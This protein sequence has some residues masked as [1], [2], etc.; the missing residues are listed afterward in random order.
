[1]TTISVIVGSI[2]QG[3]FS[4]LPAKWIFEHLK[5]REGVDARLLDLK[6]FPL[7][8]FDAPMAPAWPGRPPYEHPEVQRWTAAIAGSDAYVFVTPEYNFGASGV[9][10]NA[11]DWVYPEW[12]RKACAFVSFGG[13]GGARA[14][15]Q[16]RENVIELQ[17]APIRTSVHIP[18]ATL[19][20]YFQGA[21][22][23]KN[24]A[25]SDSN[26][27]AMIDELLWW[28]EALQTARAKSKRS[29]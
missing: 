3:R 10:K 11:I 20:A 1:M 13:A 15:Q 12:N 22:V 4:E 2:R 7:P 18:A 25:D 17:M 23:Q 21:D 16:L 8:F 19:R 28:T 9:L 24:L 29:D 27:Q 26:A 5:K 6:E 14:V